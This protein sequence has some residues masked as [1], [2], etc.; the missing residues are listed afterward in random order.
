MCVVLNKFKEVVFM[1][2]GIQYYG[3]S[4]GNRP[5]HRSMGETPEDMAKAVKYQEEQEAKAR[6]AS[7][8]YRPRE[9]GERPQDVPSREQQEKYASQAA[10]AYGSSMIT[11]TD[12]SSRPR[13][14]GE[15]PDEVAKSQESKPKTADEMTEQ[16]R[17]I[18][19]Y[20]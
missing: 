3:T 2:T 20:R 9:M 7:D 11:R 1:F 16:E 6:S 19:L 8:S 10:A 4:Y 15:T 12:N 17:I 14:M 18:D 13:E 5:F